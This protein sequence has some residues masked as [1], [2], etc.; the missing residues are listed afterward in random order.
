[1]NI[2]GL[3]PEGTPVRLTAPRYSHE[4]RKQMKAGKNKKS[5][6]IKKETKTPRSIPKN[7]TAGANAC[8]PAVSAKRRTETAFGGNESS[9]RMIIENSV[10]SVFLLDRD[11]KFLLMNANAAALLAGE[12]QDFI[13]KSVFDLGPRKVARKF[14]ELIRNIID[15]GTGRV[16]EK[17]MDFPVGQRTLLVNTQV[18]KIA[19]GRNVVLMASC[20]DITERKRM[21]ERLRLEKARTSTILAGIADT[22]YSLDAD[23]RFTVVNP[24]AEKAPFGRPAGDLLGKVIWDLYPR[25]LGTEIHG[26]YIAAARKRALEHYEAQSPLNGRWYEVFMQ[27]WQGGVDVYMRD[28]TERKG[29][30]EALRHSKSQL[31]NALSMGRLGHW[32]LDVA[33]GMFTFSDNFY[34]IFR[35]TAAEAGGYRM[36]I[37]EYAKRFVHP[38]DASKVGEETRKALEADDPHFTRYIEHRML[39]ADG[40]TGHIAVRF[41]IVKNSGG[42]TVKT[43]GVNQDITEI[44]RMEE[45]LQKS[46]KLESL[47]L[48]AG[49]IAHDF[50]NLLGGI[51]GYVEMAS[52][53]AAKGPVAKNLAK[54]LSTIDRARG[55]T[56]QLLTFA[57]GGAP[58]KKL[59]ALVP[60]I[61]ET[62]NF[63]LSGSNVS[64]RFMIDDALWSCEFDK[65]QIGQ[66][67]DNIVINA[68][69]AMPEGG[70]LEIAADNIVISERDHAGLRAGNYV[71]IVITDHGIGMPK[72]ILPKIFDPFFTTKAKGHGLGLATCYSIIVRHDGCLEVESEPG[73]GSTFTILLPAAAGSA[74]GS[75][76]ASAR[77][78]GG[79]GTFLVMDDEEVMRDIIGDM[80]E[81]F[82]YSV[83][84]KENGRDAVDFFKGEKEKVTAMIFDLT[85]PGGMGGREAIGE[86]RRICPETPVFVVSG[87]AEDPVMADPARYGFTASISKPFRKAQLASLLDKYVTRS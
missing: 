43:Y 67:I 18:V 70:L 68:L 15:T 50:N 35:T 6:D 14:L 69:Q 75:G 36:S 20:V 42:Q 1:M 63:A 40:S 5:A 55:L 25:L 74:P 10:T 52:E 86:I 54:A 23:W 51:Y 22:F 80:L 87:Y 8:T 84:L 24:A 34:A 49:G 13:G 11:G 33:S 56:Q 61:E 19:N 53:T 72:E 9:F 48:L 38:D 57:K 17:T 37:E 45:E 30:E 4:K 31:S 66:V 83:V 79:S 7:G 28:I 41:F 32:E 29:T 58:I 73:K 47:G 81:S 3:R 65:N 60:F 78:H 62:A 46:Q 82:G 26:H 21:E 27:G 2:L 85:I 76:E 77:M 16:H 39:Y 71:K 64:P 44:K 12:P 59:D